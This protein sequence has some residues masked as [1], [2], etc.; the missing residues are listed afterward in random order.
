VNPDGPKRTLV[1]T[2]GTGPLSGSEIRKTYFERLRKSRVVY[3]MMIARLTAAVSRG[4][5]GSAVS[6]GC[7]SAF[8]RITDL[9]QI[10]RHVREKFHKRESEWITAILTPSFS[11]MLTETELYV[12]HRSP[13]QGKEPVMSRLSIAFV[14]ALTATT[15]NAQDTRSEQSQTPAIASSNGTQPFLF[16]GRMPGDGARQGARA[17][18]RHPIAG[19]IVVPP[20]A[21]Q[22]GHK[23]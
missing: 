23:R 8:L 5:F 12:A 20:E 17:D 19:V 2:S 22:P 10:S 21:S 11:P 3:P 7:R 18:A 6:V 1:A 4:G 15:A 13:A 14:L 16:D 9:C